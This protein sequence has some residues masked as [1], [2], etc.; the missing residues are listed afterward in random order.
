MRNPKGLL[1]KNKICNKCS[2]DR[3]KAKNPKLAKAREMRSSAMS[4]SKK[5]GFE[6]TIEVTDGYN[7]M[8]EICPILK[9][10]LKYNGN[11]EKNSASLDRIDSTKGYTK[12]N[13]QVISYLANL[14]KSNSTIEEQLLFAEYIKDKYEE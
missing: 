14:M 12:D 6:F 10:E 1:V 2:S 11:K 8:L 3:L 13:I 5:K 9:M 4:R 7:M